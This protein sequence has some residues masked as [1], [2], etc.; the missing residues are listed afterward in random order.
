MQS[1]PLNLLTS[2]YSKGTKIEKGR[3]ETSTS[4]FCLSAKQ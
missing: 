3:V 1:V 2:T 4:A